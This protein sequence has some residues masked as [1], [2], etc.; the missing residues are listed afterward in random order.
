MERCEIAKCAGDYIQTNRLPLWT[1]EGH[2]AHTADKTVCLVR[3][4]LIIYVPPGKTETH[5]FLPHE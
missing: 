5:P 1:E 4:Y 3:A 2:S